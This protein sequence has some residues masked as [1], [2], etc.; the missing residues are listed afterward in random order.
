L[1]LLLDPDPAGV[2]AR[3]VDSSLR[4]F[5]DCLLPNG[6][7]VAAP[8]QMS[9][10]PRTAK[11]YLYCWPGRDL[12]FSL[13]GIEAVGRDVRAPVLRWMLDR[14]EGFRDSGLIYEEYHPNGPRRGP[15]WQPD[16]A[17]T[18]LW[19]LCRAP[20]PDDAAEREVV[21]LVADGLQRHWTS[22]GFDRRHRDLWERRFASP[23]HG[24]NLTYT[25]AACA[26]GLLLAG[27]V[28]HRDDWHGT[29]QSMA[30]LVTASADPELGRYLRRSGMPER[31]DNI[32]ASLL[33][34]VWP[35]DVVQHDSVLVATVEE[36][37]RHLLDDTGVRRYRFDGYDG[38]VVEVGAEIRQGAGAWPLLTFWLAIVYHRLG[39]QDEAT[40]LFRIGVE[41]ANDMGH[42]PEQ[43]FRAEDTRVGVSPLL[44]SHMKFLLAADEL[45]LLPQR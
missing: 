14:A 32:D 5:D 19:S 12:G 2:V 9:Y 4:V 10:Y 3:L 31:D 8:S 35:F 28:Y 13:A 6:C 21:E 20:R 39:R 38:E 15:E 17:G 34:L 33:G 44:W 27:D 26:K 30:E 43:R 36:I 24:S 41:S 25:L 40:R 42:L 29:G 11:S 1:I 37:E 22:S 23:R 16:Q 7:L 45:G 18:L